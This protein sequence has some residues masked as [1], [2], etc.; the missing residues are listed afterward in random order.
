MQFE[1]RDAPAL[2]V[3]LGWNAPGVV[4]KADPEPAISFVGRFDFEAA[5]P[6]FFTVECDLLDS[7]GAEIEASEDR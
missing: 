1:L 7:R 2:D 3:D 6:D 5:R 4:G